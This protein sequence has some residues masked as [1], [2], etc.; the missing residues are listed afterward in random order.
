MPRNS[1]TSASQTQCDFYYAHS[2][3][4]EYAVLCKGEIGGK[5]YTSSHLIG[6]ICGVKI[7][8][9]MTTFGM[10]QTYIFN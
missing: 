8:V 7:A 3:W 6:K 10:R 4:Q 2:V 1:T 9:A 5:K